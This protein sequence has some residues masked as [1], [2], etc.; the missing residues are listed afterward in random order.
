MRQA[1]IIAAPGLVA[2]KTM[3]ERLEEDHINARKLAD[4]FRNIKGLNIAGDIHTNIVMLDTSGTCYNANETVEIFK[5]RGILAG[6][7]DNYIIRFVTHKYI[8]SEDVDTAL[9]VAKQVFE[10]KLG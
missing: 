7:I 8:S 9:K 1:G 6:A 3:V 2:L 5:K 10:N 4:G